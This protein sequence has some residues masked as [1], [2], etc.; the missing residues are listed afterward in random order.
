MI[1]SDLSKL[2]VLLLWLLKSGS[3]KGQFTGAVS[4]CAPSVHQG[5]HCVHRMATSY[6]LTDTTFQQSENHGVPRC[7]HVR[8]WPFYRFPSPQAVIGIRRIRNG[9]VL[10][11]VRRRWGGG[12]TSQHSAQDILALLLFSILQL[13]QAVKGSSPP[14]SGK[15]ARQKKKSSG[16]RTFWL[17]L[18]RGQNIASQPA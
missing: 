16:P 15:T 17:L 13:A 14:K 10:C 11:P 18:L 7:M 9:D 12:A 3:A 1:S 6:A 8:S 5:A 2:L 4:A